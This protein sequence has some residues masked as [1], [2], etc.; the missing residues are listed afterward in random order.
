ML[1]DATTRTRLS[2][3]RAEVKNNTWPI[4]Y[5]QD[6]KI[7]WRCYPFSNRD[8]LDHYEPLQRISAP[9]KGQGDDLYRLDD[10]VPVVA[11]SLLRELMRGHFSSKPSAHA[12]AHL[13]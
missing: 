3:C 2:S 11:G 13:P 8:N 4:V 1:F 9:P 12:R 7:Y 6:A 10:Y 5:D